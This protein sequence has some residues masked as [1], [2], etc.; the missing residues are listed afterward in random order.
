MRGTGERAAAGAA[1]IDPVKPDKLYLRKQELKE[2]KKKA[3]T[4]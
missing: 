3:E 2:K 4:M 1:A